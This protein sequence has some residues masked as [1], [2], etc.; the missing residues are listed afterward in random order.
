MHKLGLDAQW[1]QLAV[2][3]VRTASYSILINGLP[4]ITI[5]FLFMC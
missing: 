1:I 4:L 5:H 3:T 2:E